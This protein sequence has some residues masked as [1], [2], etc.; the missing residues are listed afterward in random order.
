MAWFLVC[1]LT[2]Q[3][4]NPFG[5]ASE[6]FTGR[7]HP[8]RMLM[9]SRYAR[10]WRDASHESSLAALDAFVAQFTSVVATYSHQVRVVNSEGGAA[11]ARRWSSRA[12][13]GRARRTCSSG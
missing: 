6:Q 12:R 3:Q 7:A 2:A 4:P 11:G 1:G 13:G 8:P 5:T 9:P 10:E